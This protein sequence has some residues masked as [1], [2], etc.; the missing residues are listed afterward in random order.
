MNIVAKRPRDR[1]FPDFVVIGA[2]RAGTTSL[3]TMLAKQPGICLPAMKETDYFIRGKN[4]KRGEAWYRSRFANPELCC[5]DVS[6]N[7]A[8]RDAFREVPELIHEANPDVKLLYVVRDPVERALSHYRH[9]YLIG[10]NAMP[11]PGE[12][13]GSEI[14]NH[15]LNTSRYAWQMEQWLELFSEEQIM[16]VDFDKLVSDTDT[17]M[18]AISRFLDVE[19]T[20]AG[21]AENNNSS[22]EL[23]A[24]PDWWVK[25]RDSKM[26]NNLRAILPRDV[27]QTAKKIVTSAGA[28]KA[29]T[30]PDFVKPVLDNIREVLHPDTV[31]LRDMT[32]HNFAHWSV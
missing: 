13:L 9:S 6:P 21:T 15:I 14:G 8:K 30:S 32:G 12:L 23:G 25:L 3:H 2:M 31:R 28:S 27:V 29:R 18:E 22:K 17:E 10:S 5:G 16:L 24:T 11:E 26:G 19:F 20:S 1:M 7:Y 4:Y